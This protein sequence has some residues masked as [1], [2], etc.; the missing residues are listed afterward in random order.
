MVVLDSETVR[1]FCSD[2]A[3]VVRGAFDTDWIEGLRQGVD[4]NMAA[5][6]PNTKAYTKAGDSGNFFGDSCNW[7]RIDAYRDFLF[8]SPAK[9]LAAELMGSTKVNLFHEHVLV[10]EPLTRDRT[11]WHHDQPYYCVDGKDNGSLW[12]PLDPVPRETCVEYVAGS[13]RW[14]KWFTPTK[15]VGAQYERQDEGYETVPD[16]DATRDDYHLLSWDLE[17]GDCI[18]FHFL[19]VHGSPRQPQQNHASQSLRRK[20]HRGRRKVRETQRPN[21]TTFSGRDAKA[22]RRNGLPYLSG[23]DTRLVA[24]YARQ[25][26]PSRKVISNTSSRTPVIF[27][28]RLWTV[29]TI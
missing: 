16:I 18:A 1:T 29:L 9:H 28:R 11:A 3:T 14:G 20:I 25:P 22:R 21:G 5:P 2:G 19:T 24:A 15:F 10:K 12:I 8:N 27:A 6:G 17:P 26:R 13:H 23:T 4:E 7:Q